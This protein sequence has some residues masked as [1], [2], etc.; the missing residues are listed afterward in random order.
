MV[1]NLTK[2]YGENYRK[3]IEKQVD[4]EHKKGKSPEEAEK[5][6]KENVL[7]GEV[8]YSDMMIESGHFKTYKFKFANAYSTSRKISA[9]VF[10]RVTMNYSEENDK[11]DLT[12]IIINI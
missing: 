1:E 11:N 4:E 6:V 8:L 2:Q 12:K 7:T 9:I 3:T 5:N 10:E